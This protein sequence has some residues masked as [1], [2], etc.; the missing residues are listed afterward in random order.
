MRALP[1]L[2]RG[3]AKELGLWRP[4]TSELAKPVELKLRVTD[5]WVVGSGAAAG[6]GADGGA[7]AAATEVGAA[8]TD[9]GV[10]Y[11]LPLG[12]IVFHR[13]RAILAGKEGYGGEARSLHAA[14]SH[15]ASTAQP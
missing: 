14:L 7:G 9:A 6:A 15:V 5:P 8:A 13:E 1:L 2:D 4:L 3:K 11:E 10:T 12:T